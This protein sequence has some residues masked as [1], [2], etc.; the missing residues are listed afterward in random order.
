MRAFFAFLGLALGLW[1][2]Y[3]WSLWPLAAVAVC[4]AI[5]MLLSIKR[6]QVLVFVI[7][8]LIGLAAGS[9]RYVSPDQKGNF[10]GLV[11]ETKNDYFIF[12]SKLTR[13]YVSEIDHK[14]EIGDVLSISGK[15][16][17]FFRTTYESKFD[18][19]TYLESKGVRK[20]I[21]P[22][23]I[24]IVFEHPFRL[25]EKEKEFLSHYDAGTQSLLDSVLFNRKD[26]NSRAIS[27]AS[28]LNLLALFSASGILFSILFRGLQRLL[29]LFISKTKAQVIVAVVATLLFPLGL[30]KIGVIR[31]YSS[32]IFRLI[33]ET[34]L[35]R[36]FEYLEIISFTGIALLV[37]DRYLVYQMGF[38][39]GFGL[40]LV[41]FFS[42]S[43]L[44]RKSGKWRP[45][46]VP[47]LIYAFTLPFCI[48]E[49]GFHLFQIVFNFLALPFAFGFYLVGM[50]SFLT[51]PFVGLLN[52]LASSTENLLLLFARIDVHAAIP[53]LSGWFCFLYYLGFV[54][55][56]Y[57]DE[58]GMR[59][60]RTLLIITVIAIYLFGLIP[61]VPTI[62][63]QIS[64][65]NVGQG[66]SIL[67]RDGLTAVMIDTGGNMGFD[68]AKES[69]IPFLL[70]ERVYKIDCLIA[71]HG[72]FDHIG[73][74]DS[75]MTNIKVERFI[76]DPQDFPL[77]IGS[78]LFTNYNTYRNGDDNASSLVLSLDFMDKIWLFTG[79]APIEI[80]NDIIADRPNL[81]C[82]IL[83]LGHHGSDTSS[84]PN[85]LETLHP[86]E[87][88][89]SVGAKN[90]YG[91][92]SK[93][94]LDQL[95]RLGIKIRRTDREGTITYRKIKPYW[96]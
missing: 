5:S 46:A 19:K 53:A 13:Y 3:Q 62:T 7:A 49:N 78:C 65:I 77:Q 30:A 69:L 75:L 93:A 51:F 94:V 71:S 91:H 4:F 16:F 96:L 8:S 6:R 52:Y 17:D 45:I 84:S 67:I 85:F 32:L 74:K 73:A 48:N 82:D 92:P 41:V 42:R 54:L 43:L 1:L 58:I 86:K 27:I 72:D 87:A 61:I 9:F 44:K 20:E 66:D 80:E 70:K 89:I 59:T 21:K 56:L 60:Q 34:L 12:T 64:F 68:M 29:S 33:N 31:V 40:S 95:T 90:R 28:S 63:Q 24:R 57:L 38:L 14:R 37:I 26:Y 10:Q 11:I 36:R 55:V 35:K 25:R 83:K 88:I 23:Q 2:A 15:S 81:R 47:I 39:L 22:V 18:F 50:T 79:D 76:N